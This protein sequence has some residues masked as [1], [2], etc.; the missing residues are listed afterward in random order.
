ML[1]RTTIEELLCG[2]IVLQ[3]DVD[4]AGEIKRVYRHQETDLDKLDRQVVAKALINP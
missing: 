1:G 3:F 2:K 4:K